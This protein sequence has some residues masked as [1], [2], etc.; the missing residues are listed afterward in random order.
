MT[1]NSA[2]PTIS[3]VELAIAALYAIAHDTDAPP[4]VRFAAAVGL[5]GREPTAECHKAF[6]DAYARALHLEEREL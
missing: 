4:G 5:D 6:A 3:G 2:T 1:E